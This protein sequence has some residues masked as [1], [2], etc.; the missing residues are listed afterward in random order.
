MAKRLEGNGGSGSGY[1]QIGNSTA[2]VGLCLQKA[3]LLKKWDEFFVT[4]EDEDIL[5]KHWA[6]LRL[7][8]D[9]WSHDVEKKR[10]KNEISSVEKFTWEPAN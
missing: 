4:Y 2:G 8:I 5:G 6:Q 9:E 3:H 1:M 7:G 10:R